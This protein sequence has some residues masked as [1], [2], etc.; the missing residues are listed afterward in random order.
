[1]VIV[2][3]SDPQEMEVGWELQGSPWADQGSAGAVVEEETWK[4]LERWAEERGRLRGARPALAG[5]K[6]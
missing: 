2:S 3:S 6:G 1:V 5:C 4:S